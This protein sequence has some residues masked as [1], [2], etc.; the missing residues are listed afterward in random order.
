MLATNLKI[1]GVVLGTI[2]FYTY[3]AGSIPQVESEVPE[4]LALG[5]D[6]TVDELVAAGEEL[7]IGAGG[8]TACHGT[9]TRAPNLLEPDGGTG[10]IGE[11]CGQRAPD[12]SCKDYL[13]QS[14]V[15]PNAFIVDGFQP[16]MPDMSRTLSP[17]QI[18]ALV[19]YMENLGGEVTVTAEDLGGTGGEATASGAGPPATAAGPTSTMEPMAL[20]EENQCIVCHQLGDQGA[21]IGP[22]LTDIGA[23]RD[24][25]FIR[26]KIIDPASAEPAAGF[27]QLAG[28]MPQDFGTRLSAAQLEILVSY[29]AEQR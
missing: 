13:H 24:A 16:I 29:L 6:F 27:E 19:A 9:G 2:L 1:L 17:A 21:P 28:T 11:R 15:D 26:R 22:A 23:R 25:D 20:L 7:Y 3:L 5:A 18:W 12:L 8:C 14:L 4:E 10:L